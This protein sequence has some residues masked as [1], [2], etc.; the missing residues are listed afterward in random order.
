MGGGEDASAHDGGG[1]GEGGRQGGDGDED[2]GQGGDGS[3]AILS[4][5]SAKQLNRRVTRLVDA[6]ARKSEQVELKRR[7]A[8]EQKQ[9]RRAKRAAKRAVVDAQRK[10]REA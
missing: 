2:G 9:Q 5:P 8:A 7:Q 6:L 3:D 10:A 1:V 4:W